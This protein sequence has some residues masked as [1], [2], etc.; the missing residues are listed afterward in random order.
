MV[1]ERR[2]SNRRRRSICR[3]P[4]ALLSHYSITPILHHSSSGS[5]RFR[6]FRFAEQLEHLLL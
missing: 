1:K 3:L 4:A 5:P 2:F 6:L